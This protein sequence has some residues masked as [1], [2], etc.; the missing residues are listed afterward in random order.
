MRG[1]ALDLVSLLGFPMS[2]FPC[3]PAVDGDRV[4]SM[5]V[6]VSPVTMPVPPSPREKRL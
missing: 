6:L 5:V 1:K 3:F 2:T 4:G